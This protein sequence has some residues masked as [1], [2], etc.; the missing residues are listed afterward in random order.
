MIC[1]LSCVIIALASNQI[2]EVNTFFIGSKI[3]QQ[4]YSLTKNTDRLNR[5]LFA[6]STRFVIIR[7]GDS[8]HLSRPLVSDAWS[9]WRTTPST[10]IRHRLTVS[11]TSP[12]EPDSDVDLMPRR[13]PLSLP[14][15][16]MQ[17]IHFHKAP[18]A[19]PPGR[20][21]LSIDLSSERGRVAR[22]IPSLSVSDSSVRPRRESYPRLR[23]D[24]PTES[25]LLPAQSQ[26]IS[27]IRQR[28]SFGI[29]CTGKNSMGR[30]VE[31]RGRDVGR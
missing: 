18:D 9:R 23:A 11:S 1:L 4:T 20:R 6:L 25:N 7:Q 8:F 16:C 17:I 30:P 21:E 29:F 10:S 26:P 15:P 19:F 2:S 31:R 13:S 22:R 5:L 12:Q 28:R 27:G 24:P 14:S 3:Q